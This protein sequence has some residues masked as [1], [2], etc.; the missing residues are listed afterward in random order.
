VAVGEG[1]VKDG[2]G[3]AHGYSP[4]VGLYD[5]NALEDLLRERLVTDEYR[6]MIFELRPGGSTWRS[7]MTAD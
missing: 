3:E 6:M 4:R 7:P 5:Y 2:G 1:G